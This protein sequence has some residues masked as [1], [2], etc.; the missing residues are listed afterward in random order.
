MRAY[1][2]ELLNNKTMMAEKYRL[3]AAKA[4]DK[5]DLKQARALLSKSLKMQGGNQETYKTMIYYLR[6]KF[7]SKS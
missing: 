5:N 6:R 4:I 7:F 1:E 3:W 2:Y